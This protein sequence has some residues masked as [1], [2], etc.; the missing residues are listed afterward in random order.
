MKATLTAILLTV[1]LGI[2]LAVLPGLSR[3]EE[4]K[5]PQNPKALLKALEE[6]ENP[7]PNIKSCSRS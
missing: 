1:A 2:G 4:P 5:L 3:A 6:A 7:V